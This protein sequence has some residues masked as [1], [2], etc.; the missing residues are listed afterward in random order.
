MK[1]V[2]AHWFVV[3]REH[4]R[5]Q[6]GSRLDQSSVNDNHQLLDE[7]RNLYVLG[8]PQHFTLEQLKSLFDPFGRVLHAVILAVLD[9]FSRRRGFVV[10]STNQEAVNAMKRLSGKVIQYVIL[11]YR[12]LRSK[13]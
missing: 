4:Q 13:L 7:R 10:M 9:A 6:H 1:A 5:K 12:L 8:V 2:V 11:R 3:N